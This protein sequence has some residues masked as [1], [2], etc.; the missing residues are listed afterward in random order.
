MQNWKDGVN[1]FVSIQGT[2]RHERKFGAILPYRGKS[3]IH[4]RFEQDFSTHPHLQIEISSSLIEQSPY[5]A[6]R[7]EDER[8]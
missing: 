3:K 4:N 2:R 6:S 5:L 7:F 8:I 1:H